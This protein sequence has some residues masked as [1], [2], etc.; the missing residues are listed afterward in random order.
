MQ[1]F[2]SNQAEISFS[3][4]P[5]SQNGVFPRIQQK[6]QEAKPAC[7]EGDI[8]GFKPE[9]REEKLLKPSCKRAPS[10]AAGAVTQV[11]MAAVEKSSLFPSSDPQGPPW[12][13]PVLLCWQILDKS[14]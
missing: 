8:Q 11:H 5:G 3:F 2:P 13:F 14:Q 6:T 1:R 10:S 9:Q 12:I 7:R 4:P